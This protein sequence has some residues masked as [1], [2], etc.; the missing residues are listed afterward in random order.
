M[1]K[2]I[3]FCRSMPS[4]S[5][6]V[7]TSGD[8][9]E[10]KPPSNN[11]TITTSS[12]TTDATE[13][14]SPAKNEKVSHKSH[15]HKSRHKHKHSHRK[16]HRVHATES[17]LDLG[18]VSEEQGPPAPLQTAFDDSMGQKYK[19]LLAKKP[20]LSSPEDDGPPLPPSMAFD[21]SMAKKSDQT[22]CAIPVE[23]S[24]DTSDTPVPLS[25]QFDDSLV[26]ARANATSTVERPDGQG[27]AQSRIVEEVAPPSAPPSY[28]DIPQVSDDVSTISLPTLNRHSSHRDDRPITITESQNQCGM[29]ESDSVSAHS[30]GDIE[31][32]C[33][34]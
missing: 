31:E 2:R 27:A 32:G 18:A 19:G 7:T 8:P 26:K 6:S 29:P 9:S 3:E 34:N 23:H 5:S 22:H 24:P 20:N 13:V 11:D 28:L 1:A 15:H 16:K 10:N 33:M 17:E 14:S 30:G 25:M 12:T 4:A 21:D